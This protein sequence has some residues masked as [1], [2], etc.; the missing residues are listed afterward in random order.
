[1]GDFD[2]K[3]NADAI[4]KARKYYTDASAGSADSKK[5]T[6]NHFKRNHPNKKIDYIFTTKYDIRVLN[7]KVID[8][9]KNGIYASDHFPIMATVEII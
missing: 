3:P 1:M 8:T 9:V 7:Y 2:C 5:G 6:F 4:I